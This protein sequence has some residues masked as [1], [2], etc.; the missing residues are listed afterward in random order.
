MPSLR[1]R[2]IAVNGQTGDGRFGGTGGALG[3]R[4][5]RG[6][7]YATDMPPGTR[8]VAGQW[9]AP[10]YQGPPLISL[11]AS[12]A[13]G[14]GIGVGDTM[15]FNILGRDI[16][17]TIGNLRAIDYTTL[18]MNFAV[19]FAPGTLE[20]APDQLIA[21]VEAT[22]EAEPVVRE[23]VLSQFANVTAIRVKDA[24]DTVASVIAN[25]S[26]AAR[27]VA[28]LALIAGTLVLAGAIAAGRRARIYDAVVL[29]VLGATRRNVLAAYLVEYALIGL[30][31]SAIAGVLGASAAWLIVTKLMRAPWV[32]LPERRL[33]LTVILCTLAVTIRLHRHLARARPEGFANFASPLSLLRHSPMG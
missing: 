14:M 25:V 3:V 4:S 10:D 17:A 12:I 23:A 15:T 24:I 5:D 8:L 2:I 33:V 32:F 1:A 11:D 27:A 19:V 20:G 30:A 6:L 7:T 22:A 21:T 13:N 31:A 18:T 16:T 28:A 9:W 29:K 26:D